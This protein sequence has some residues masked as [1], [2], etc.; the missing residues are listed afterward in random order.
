MTV[1]TIV[2]TMTLSLAINTSGLIY[3]VV[4]LLLLA[5]AWGCLTYQ[6]FQFSAFTLAVSFNPCLALK[7]RSLTIF[8]W[9]TANFI[10]QFLILS[11]LVGVPMLWLQMTLGATIRVS[12][13][14]MWQ[15][16]PIC[17]GIGIALLVAHG[18]CIMRPAFNLNFSV[19]F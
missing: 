2:R 3:L 14:G 4:H 6:G 9:V 19:N 11:F 13:I 17:K 10:V 18:V 7:D 12:P 1:C 8:F 5:A 15:I 16:S